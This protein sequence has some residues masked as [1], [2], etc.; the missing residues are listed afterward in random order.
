MSSSI[1][2]PALPPDVSDESA[3]YGVELAGRAEWIERLSDTEIVEVESAI[4]E[5]DKSQLIKSNL[6]RC[7]ELAKDAR[8][9]TG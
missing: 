9:D 1:H 4:H 5:L 3:W 2:F 7:I 6:D 8:R